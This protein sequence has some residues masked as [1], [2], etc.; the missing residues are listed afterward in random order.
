MTVHSNDRITWLTK[1]DRIGKLSAENKDL[2][3]NN[4]GHLINADM[5][6]E[7]YRQLDGTRAV[8]IDNMTKRKYGKN[9]DNNLNDIIQKI[10]R[11]TYKP[12]PARITQIPKE[13][14]SNRPLA[15]SCLEDKLIQSAVSQILTAIYEPLFLSCSYGYRSGKSCHD[16]LKALNQATYKHPHGAIVEIDIRKYFNTIPHVVLMELLRKKISDRRFLRMIE[17]LITAPIREDN[18]DK[19]NTLGCPQGSIISPILANIYLHHV[20]DEWF[21]NIKHT[22][23]NGSAELVRFADDMVFSFA[24]Q[25]DAKRFYRVLPKRL[26]KAGLEMHGAKSSCIPAGRLVAKNAELTGKRLDTFN[27]LGFTCYWGKS[28]KGFWRLKFTSRKDRFAAKL[29]GLKLYLRENLNTNDTV[30]TVKTV[31]RVVQGWVNYHAV[32]DNNRRVNSFLESSKRIIL[33]WLNRR[34][35]KRKTNWD[36]LLIGLKLL[37]FPTKWK[38]K[39]M[40]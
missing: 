21:E 32:S 37:G 35:G 16:A 30:G 22:H 26:S 23:L 11:G 2:T 12:K 25:D 36:Q 4:I 38:V 1:L 5:L 8:G 19:A 3:F 27:F 20:I 24:R 39:S 40:F 15:I 29:K 6:K 9:L 31:I 7:Q 17:V 13:D 34:G 10:R 14:G 18:E 33:R 28:R